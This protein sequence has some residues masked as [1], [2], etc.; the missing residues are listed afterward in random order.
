[1]SLALDRLLVD[2]LI[3]HEGAHL[4]FPSGFVRPSNVHLFELPKGGMGTLVG[5]AMATALGLPPSNSTAIVNRMRHMF[6][7]WP[8]LVAEYKPAFGA[9]FA[10][11]LVN[12]T[13]WGYSDLDVVLGQLPRP[14]TICNRACNTRWQR[15]QH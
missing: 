5:G 15:L 8:R 13:H 4:P 7:K 10:Q 1:M 6:Q 14:A 2:W 12:Y 11:Y 3:F 9:V